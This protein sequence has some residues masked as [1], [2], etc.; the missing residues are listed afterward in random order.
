MDKPSSTIRSLI[1]KPT[2]ICDFACDFCS[3]PKLSESKADRLSL[4]QVFEFLER[5]PDTEEI[6]ING[7]DPLMMP[8]E[9]YWKLIRH[10]D[11][12]G[13]K[14]HISF[15]TNL[16][17]FFNNPDKWTEL[18]R[19][20]RMGVCTS[21]QYGDKRKIN[22]NRVYTEKDFI[23]VSDLF[24]E[25]VGYRPDF[26]AVVDEDNL[27]QVVDMVRLAKYLGVEAKV[28]YAV[29]SGYQSKPLPLSKIYEQYVKIYKEG[30]WQW[31]Y[32]T[33]RMVEKLKGIQ[34]PCPLLRNCDEHIRV[35]HPDGKYFSCGSIADDL[36]YE[37]DFKAEMK[38]DLIKPLQS[39]PNLSSLKDECYS[40]PMFQICNGCKKH[41]KDLKRS[42]MVETHCAKMKSIADDILEIVS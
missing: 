19:H 7:G 21:F 29:A 27:H 12:K 14:A 30:L 20:P 17:N 8:L 5:H 39:D 1:L 6:I 37:I 9:Y 10:L 15:T 34:T 3:S 4:E 11:E 35:L 25:R 32:N 31:E 38:G 13:Y 26:I 24:L 16:W 42:G 36:E 22:K 33:K 41:I 40:C 28:N 23:A 18:F 2:E